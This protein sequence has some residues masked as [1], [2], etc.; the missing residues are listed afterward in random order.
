MSGGIASSITG[1]R[2]SSCSRVCPTPLEYRIKVVMDRDNVSRQKAMSTLK[3]DDEERYRW[4]RKLF[5]V[6][7]RDCNLYDLVLNIDK[8]SV[9]DAVGIICYFA[10]FEG[11]Q[12]TP[13]SQKAMDDLQ[14]ACVVK[15]RLVEVKPDARVSADG[16]TVFVETEARGPEEEDAAREV[17][18]IAEAVPGV[19]DVV[20]R[21]PR[22]ASH[23]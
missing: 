7:Q 3:R 19:S 1:W 15:A 12:A 6:D 20:I 21:A 4:S 18:R 2:D 5:L 14:L 22:Q 23:D 17:K 10:G 11:F 9:E 13:E 16:G 8:C